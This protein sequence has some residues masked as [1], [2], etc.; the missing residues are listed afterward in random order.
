MA[1]HFHYK[2]E[3]GKINCI[4]YSTTG[5]AELR[6]WGLSHNMNTRPIVENGFIMPH[7]VVSGFRARGKPVDDNVF[8]QEVKDWEKSLRTKEENTRKELA[9]RSAKLQSAQSPILKSDGKTSNAELSGMIDWSHPIEIKDPENWVP[10]T[11][12]LTG[13]FLVTPKL[14]ERML[15]F[16]R[17]QRPLSEGKVIRLATRMEEGWL[18]SH[19]GLG[20]D[21]EGKMNDGQHRGNALVLAGVTIPFPIM[22]GTDPNTFEIIDIDV[23]RNVPDLVTIRHGKP[24]PVVKKLC[25]IGR[26]MMIGLDSSNISIIDKRM[27]AEFTEWYLD[28]IEEF[29]KSMRKLPDWTRPAPVIAAFANAVRGGD[30]WPGG[31]GGRDK[32]TVLPHIRR[33]A[34]QDWSGAGDPMKSLFLRM[35]RLRNV[36]GKG[37]SGEK[38]RHELYGMAMNAMRQCL[39]EETGSRVY[40]GTIE[41][42]TPEDRG[43]KPR[44]LAFTG[45]RVGEQNAAGTNA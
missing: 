17:G 37:A 21:W 16:A 9:I 1:I 33:Y 8:K 36:Q 35:E 4:I 26:S 42:G 15:T 30:E 24:I 25:A 41:W 2:P 38:D 34:N 27:Q 29:Y 13:V 12:S 43:K 18:F 11:T 5:K 39:R 7:Y 22:F 32:A 20:F 14:M 6:A 10:P 28:L 3:S 45:K 44:Y 23:N 31:H 19:Q 40:V